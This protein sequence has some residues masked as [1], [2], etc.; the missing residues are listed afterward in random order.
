MLT[1][2]SFHNIGVGCNKSQCDPGRSKITGRKEDWG[3]FRTPSLRNVALRQVYFHDGS[4]AT[5]KQAVDFHLRGGCN[6]K[7]LDPLLKPVHLTAQERN[8]LLA[9]LNSLTSKDIA[10]VLNDALPKGI[11]H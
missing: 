5:L 9:F 1:D 8:D 11:A 4:A 7:N 3:A 10:T 6:N 2:E